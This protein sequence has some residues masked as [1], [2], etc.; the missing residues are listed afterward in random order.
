MLYEVITLCQPLAIERDLLLRMEEVLAFF[1]HGHIRVG[2]VCKAFYVVI[3]TQKVLCA[4][5]QSGLLV[6]YDRMLDNV[7]VIIAFPY[8][9]ASIK[10]FPTLLRS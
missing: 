10:G 6:P 9:S 3:F 8:F 5:E 2:T 4:V 7:L 1:K